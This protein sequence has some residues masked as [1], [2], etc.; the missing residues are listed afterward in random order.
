MTQRDPSYLCA[1]QKLDAD[2]MYSVQ[3]HRAEGTSNCEGWRGWW[4][5]VRNLS[6]TP[7]SSLANH[8]PPLGSAIDKLVVGDWSL[9]SAHSVTLA[10]T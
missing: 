2:L 5:A 1:A 8:S 6:S 9:N 3:D 4:E 7:Y 10:S